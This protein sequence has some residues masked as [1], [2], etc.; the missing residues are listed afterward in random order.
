MEAAQAQ[1][2][3]RRKKG[4]KRIWKTVKNIFKEK[5]S[6]VTPPTVVTTQP[7]APTVPE[8]STS[9]EP[10]KPAAVSPTTDEEQPSGQLKHIEVDDAPEEL[11]DPV[12]L[13]L[14]PRQAQDNVNGPESRFRRAQAIFAQYNIHL[15][16][17]DWDMKPQVFP[18]RVSKNIRMRVRYTCHNCSTTFGHDRVCVGCQHRRCTQ[19]SRYPPKRDQTRPA[20]TPTNP[21][22]PQ[23]GTQTAAPRLSAEGACHECQTGLELG[24]QACPNCHH[25]ICERCVQEA[26]ITVEHGP[27]KAVDLSTAGEESAIV[28]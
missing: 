14:Q 9:T 20:A 26:T 6:T 10:S 16:E 18:E 22:L 17:D 13:S 7:V 27:D 5:P 8:L 25:R 21:A 28:S 19:C 4:W 24:T 11:P 3:P 23:V 15:S 2:S 12:K 1:P